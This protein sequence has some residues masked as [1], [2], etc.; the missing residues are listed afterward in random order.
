MRS[1]PTTSRAGFVSSFAYELPFGH[2]R[3]F[4][5]N[6]HGV[7]NVLLSGFQVNG[8][9]NY[10]SGTPVVLGGIT[11]QTGLLGGGQRPNS[12]LRSA[13]IANANSNEWFNIQAFALPAQFTIGNAPRVLP[14]V[15]NPGYT[16]ADLS[17]FKN[18]FI[19]SHERYNLQ[20]RLETFN[21][22]NHPYFSARCESGRRAAQR[23]GHT[24]CR[25]KY[26]LRQD[27]RDCRRSA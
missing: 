3:R 26:Q 18:N 12:V 11:D 27:H 20:L 13:R 23:R 4:L 24:G 7:G 15:R 10:N 16:N 17:I 21:A 6:V 22:F 14:D 2:G 8:I 19:G 1:R 9:V 25:S 5:N